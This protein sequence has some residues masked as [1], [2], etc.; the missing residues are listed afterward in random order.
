[1]G[2]NALRT[3]H[4]MPAP[5]VMELADELGF[6]VVAEAFDMWEMPKTQYDYA[7][8]F[9]DW[10]G[11]D[12]RSWVRRD[13]SHVSLLMWS[14]GNEIYDTH[15]SEHGQ[16]ITRKLMDFVREHDPR[17]NAPC[18]IGSNYMPWEGAQKCAEIVGMAGYNYAEGYYKAHHREHP[19]W[20]IYGSE[21]ASVIKSRGIY[22]FPF[23]HCILTDEDEQCSSLV[24]CLSLIKI[25]V[26]KNMD[27][28]LFFPIRPL[29]LID[30]ISVL[31]NTRRIDLSKVAVFGLIG[32]RLSDII[33][34]GP[35][36]LSAGIGCI[37]VHGDTVFLALWNCL[38]TVSLREQR[39]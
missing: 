14:L 27:K 24:Y 35:Q 4:N 25:P 3:S 38:W 34:S 20:V 31:G 1:M 16:E 10:A 18:T 17:G 33:K 5:E 32:R 29:S 37:P 11:T 36:K 19:Q 12:V 21:T 22:H 39:K 28:R 2:V 7:R 6:L 9:A 13:R 30:K 15:A 8:F 26:G 23:N